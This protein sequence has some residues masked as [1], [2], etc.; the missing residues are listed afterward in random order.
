MTSELLCKT[1]A[2]VNRTD[3]KQTESVLSD[4][5]T[6]TMQTAVA[7]TKLWIRLPVDLRQADIISFQ[8]FKR[9]LKTFLFRC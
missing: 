3:G 7:D 6:A 8:R 9:L 2:N 4:G 5:P 1:R